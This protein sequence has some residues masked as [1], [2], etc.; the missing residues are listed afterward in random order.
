MYHGLTRGAAAVSRYP[1]AHTSGLTTSRW[2]R[3]VMVTTVI[4]EPCHFSHSQS[5]ANAPFAPFAPFDK[6]KTHTL[7]QLVEDEESRRLRHVVV[8]GLERG[9]KLPA[10]REAH[11]ACFPSAHLQSFICVCALRCSVP[12]KSCEYEVERSP[13]LIIFLRGLC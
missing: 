11:P 4:P 13:L 7:L 5:V 12:A 2:D 3:I 6:H 9:G 8:D 10:S 1:L